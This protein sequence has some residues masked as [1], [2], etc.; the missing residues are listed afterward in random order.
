MP[1]YRF[2]EVKTQAKRSFVCDACGKRKR[3]QQTFSMTIN[4]YNQ[5]PDGT[6]RTP[7]EVQAAVAAKA[8]AWQPT[9]CASCS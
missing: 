7:A 8:D 9:T 1:T 3:L 5:N 4:P 6:V 2:R